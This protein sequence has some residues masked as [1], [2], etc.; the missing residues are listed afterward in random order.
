MKIQFEPIWFDSLGA[1]SACCLVKTPDV[2]VLIDPGAA[3]M[4][5]GFPASDQQ[6]WEWLIQAEEA[7]LKASQQADIIVISHYHYDHFTDFDPRL[8][9]GKTLFSKNPNKYINDSQR[10][11]AENFYDNLYQHFGNIPLKEVLKKN[12]PQEYPDTMDKLPL[13]LGKDFGD[14]NRRKAELLEKGR[15]WFQGRVKRWKGNSLIPVLKFDDVGVKF[16]DGKE[17]TFG[18]TK[19]KFSEPL[20]HGIE[21]SR[22]GWIFATVIEVE[23]EKFLH[24]SDVDGPVIEDYAGFIIRENPN[25]LVLDGPMTYMFGYLV[26]RI[27]LDRAVE[28]AH[29]IVSQ[30]GA[31]LIIYDHHLP[32]EA[33]FKERTQKVWDESPK[34]MTAAEYLG[35]T[36]KVWGCG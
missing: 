16:A 15:K 28:N 5:P 25:I 20:F 33:K 21:Y 35:K 9:E 19:I 26:N 17:I 30:I 29:V 3:V 10:K 13:A 4:Q 36:P 23:G 2:S 24:S 8:Y 18:G 11:R 7:I 14:Y 27:N 6:K 1:K 32:R 12:K 31:S 22:V 34:V